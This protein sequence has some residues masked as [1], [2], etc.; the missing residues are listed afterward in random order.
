MKVVKY[1][2]EYKNLANDFKYYKPMGGA[3]NINCLA[4][5]I[6]FQKK[7]IRLPNGESRYIS[8]YLLRHCEKVILKISKQVGVTFITLFSTERG[9]YLYHN[10]NG[11]EDFEDDMS[12][13]TKESDYSCRKLYKWIDDLKV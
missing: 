5:H 13:V 4:L 7:K 12:I 8:D 6:D 9:Y 3:I 11:Y 10:R 1:T 2:K